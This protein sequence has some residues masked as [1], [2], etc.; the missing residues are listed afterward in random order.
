MKV[1]KIFTKWSKAGFNFFLSL[2][3]SFTKGR[4]FVREGKAK[5]RKSLMSV[6]FPERWDEV[7]KI[8]NSQE[9]IDTFPSALAQYERPPAQKDDANLPLLIDL[10][11]LLNWRAWPQSWSQLSLTN[12]AYHS[13]VRK[14]KMLVSLARYVD[15]KSC[16]RITCSLPLPPPPNFGSNRFN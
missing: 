1:L 8:L 4:V 15:L 10:S 9:F 16:E 12:L 2:S 14:R 11:L 13:R 7:R 6:A 3:L 5:M